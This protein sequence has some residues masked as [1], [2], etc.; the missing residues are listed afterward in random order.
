[1]QVSNEKKLNLNHTNFSLNKFYSIEKVAELTC[2]AIRTVNENWRKEGLKI[3][4]DKIKGKDIIEFLKSKRTKRKFGKLEENEYFCTRA[5]TKIQCEPSI[6][7]KLIYKNNR[8][9]VIAN[10]KGSNCPNF[11][12]KYRAQENQSSVCNVSKII[13][14]ELAQKLYKQ[15]FCNHANCIDEEACKKL[16]ITNIQTNNL[17][18]QIAKVAITK[19][20][21]NASPKPF[22]NLNKTSQSSFGIQSNIKKMP[23]RRP[24]IDDEYSRAMSKKMEEKRR[25]KYH[26]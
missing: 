3:E 8:F 11:N 22:E 7:M 2:H 20:T 21:T 19:A 16:N 12:C 6:N 23:R 14:K 15:F 17:S 1:M 4:K 13:S 26:V 25:K 9:K 10:I 18:Q 5:K 24:L